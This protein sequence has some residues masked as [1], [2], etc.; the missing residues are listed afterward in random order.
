MVRSGAVISCRCPPISSRLG[1]KRFCLTNL[2]CR[3]RCGI[4]VDEYELRETRLLLES[5]KQEKPDRYGLLENN[6]EDVYNAVSSCER[7]Y[8]CSSNLYEEGFELEECSFG[9]ALSQLE[10]LG[11][12]EAYNDTGAGVKRYDFSE[13]NRERLETVY[14]ELSESGY[15]SSEDSSSLRG[16]P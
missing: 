8:P 12:F 7:R 13:L 15:S 1:L 9:Q 6:I 2:F 5:L 14:K 11:V 10:D 16:D 4:E 3:G